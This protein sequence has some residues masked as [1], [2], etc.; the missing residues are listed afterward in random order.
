MNTIK[1]SMQT[2]VS[3]QMRLEIKKMDKSIMNWALQMCH[4][5]DKLLYYWTVIVWCHLP[6]LM[7]CCVLDITTDPNRKCSVWPI[8]MWQFTGVEYCFHIDWPRLRKFRQIAAMSTGL[9]F[10]KVVTVSALTYVYDFGPVIELTD[11][12]LRRLKWDLESG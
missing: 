8:K 9:T 1:S 5:R 2:A 7:R 6:L 11:V 12:K 4:K 10:C 3:Y